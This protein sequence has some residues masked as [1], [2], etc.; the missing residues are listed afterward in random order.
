MVLCWAAGI[1]KKYQT[2]LSKTLSHILHP[3][4]WLTNLI[5]LTRSSGCPLTRVHMSQATFASCSLSL[6]SVVR[7]ARS[8]LSMSLTLGSRFD[9]SNVIKSDH[10]RGNSSHA[11]FSSTVFSISWKN[12]A[13]VRAII[14]TVV[15]CIGSLHDTRCMG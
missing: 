3:K 13:L 15:K 9:W 2:F 10:I 5:L 14:T 11:S 12:K 8:A 7:L 1:M 6:A 4:V